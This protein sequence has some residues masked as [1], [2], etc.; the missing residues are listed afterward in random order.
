MNV[1]TI[2][3]FLS[4]IAFFTFVMAARTG[5]TTGADKRAAQKA[6]SETEII[7]KR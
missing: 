5:L 3:F 1:A 2:E 4:V 7:T 6:E